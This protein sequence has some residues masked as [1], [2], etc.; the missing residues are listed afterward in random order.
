MN[1]A[2]GDYRPCVP[3]VTRCTQGY[4]EIITYLVTN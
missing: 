2:A 3:K 4:S 1:K